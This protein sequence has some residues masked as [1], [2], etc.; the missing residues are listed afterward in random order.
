MNHRIALAILLL[1]SY[2]GSALAGKTDKRLD[3]YWADVEG[4]AA[5]LIVTP[6]GESI[7][8][9]SGNPGTRDPDRI[10]QVATKV[11]GLEQ[12]DHL[13]T[14]HY[15]A[16]HY[17]GAAALSKVL[18]IKHVHDNGTFEGL[19]E[20]P[21]K[22]YLNFKAEKRSQLSPGEFLP[23]DEISGGPKLVLQ[24][25]AARQTVHQ[26]A[27]QNSELPTA[28]SGAQTDT[29][30]A[31]NDCCKDAQQKPIDRSDNANSIVLLL[32]FGEF[33]FFDAGD[34]TWNIEEKLVCP[35]NHIGTVDVYQVTHHGLDQSN[36]GVIVKS[37][38][39]TIAVMNNG[40]TKG[41]QPRTFATLTETESIKAIY[42]MHKNLRPDGNV[43][44]TADELIAN[45]EKDC[46]GNYIKL[47]V[48]PE[49]KTYTIS[50]PATKHERTFDVRK[51]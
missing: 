7:L 8:V 10:F 15:H 49:G 45:A 12:I 26:P 47:S 19:K 46:K 14:T 38:Q 3:I 43:N 21:P 16:D 36:N 24:C 4:G 50:I 31:D 27:L 1:L 5:T 29:A 39:P 28:K 25:L 9:D 6:T 23:I 17:G 20:P 35:K 2:S 51:K 18:P 42:Q 34:L 37:L 48:D 22:E 32:E 13:V 40:V 44:N 30:T 41:C 11:A 33:R